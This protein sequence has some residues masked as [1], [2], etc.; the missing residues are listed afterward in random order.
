MT[1]ESL[2][3][4]SSF[5]DFASN[6]PPILEDFV[7]LT[8]TPTSPTAT[9]PPIASSSS[10][11]PSSSPTMSDAE[12]SPSRVLPEVSALEA[13]TE[14]LG[15]EL[16]TKLPS[17][18]LQGYVVHTVTTNSPPSSSPPLSCSSGT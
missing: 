7:D 2:A 6:T 16:Q 13:G 5:L 8:S 3:S 4:T 15:R 18:K 17:V 11:S 12:C 10:A 1:D 14:P 9:V